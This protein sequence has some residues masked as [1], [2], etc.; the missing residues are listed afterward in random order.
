M[1]GLIAPLTFAL[2]SA[3][4]SAPPPATG[5]RD[6]TV[7]MRAV[8]AL[9]MDQ[10]AGRWQEV[11]TYLPAGASCL[12]GGVTFAP[13]SNGDLTVI[14]GPCADGKPR[15]GLARRIGPSRYMFGGE[16]LW[17]IWADF[18]Y[19]VAAIGTPNGR[20]HIIARSLNPPADKVAAAREILDWVGYDVTK[21]AP[22]RR[23]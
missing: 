12:L 1:R 2:L 14:E 9:D 13:Q 20:A 11:Q 17:L 5:F 16:E 3:C 22:A 18:E 19:S 7:P 6:P 15:N 8:A 10:F 21:L 23:R 4:V